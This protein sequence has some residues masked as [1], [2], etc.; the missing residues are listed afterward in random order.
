MRR[1]LALLCAPLPA[2]ALVACTSAVSTSSFHGV[3]HEVAQTVANLQADATSNDPKK[4]C[5]NDVSQAVVARLGGIKGCE[6]AIKRQLNEV[7][8]LELSVQ[9][10]QVASDGATATAHV[11]S[12]HEGK[13]RAGTVSLVKED[14]RWK[15]SGVA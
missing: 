2:L 15:V 3:E 7:D 14:G 12:V 5:A 10:V 4:I 6:A 1:L 13:S 11:K 8:S 9:S